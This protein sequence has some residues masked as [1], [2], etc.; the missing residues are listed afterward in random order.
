V[1]FA[2]IRVISN[3]TGDRNEQRWELKR[4]LG[5]LSALAADLRIALEPLT[6]EDRE[7]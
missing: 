1:E 6:R 3:T 5:A 4:A 2:E 7:R